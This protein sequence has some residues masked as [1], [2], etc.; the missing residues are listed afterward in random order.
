M[1]GNGAFCRMCSL[2]EAIPIHKN[3]EVKRDISDLI[4]CVAYRHERIILTSRGKPKAV[5]V[6]VTVVWLEQLCL[7]TNAG[8]ARMFSLNEH[9]FILVNNDSHSFV[10]GRMHGAT[11]PQH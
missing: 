7:L 6:S 11:M 2:V 8:R 10:Q 5:L 1:N 4:N 9:S 3:G